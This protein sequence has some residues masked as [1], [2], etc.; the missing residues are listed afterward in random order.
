MLSRATGM[1]DVPNL[2]VTILLMFLH[3][4]ISSPELL[5]SVYLGLHTSLCSPEHMGHGMYQICM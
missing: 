4:A 1:W 3:T 2:Y 5:P